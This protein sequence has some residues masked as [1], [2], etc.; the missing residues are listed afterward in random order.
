MKLETLPATEP[1]LTVKERA[2]RVL[3]WFLVNFS[4]A[5]C[6]AAEQLVADALVA[7]AREAS[8]AERAACI[9]VLQAEADYWAKRA[10]DVAAERR[11]SHRAPGFREKSNASRKAAGIVAGDGRERDRK[12]AR[13]AGA[14]VRE[15]EAPRG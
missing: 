8:G 1:G 15:A 2:N 11:Q 3:A 13:A 4:K 6:A 9:A 12:A 10:D 5:S 14:N 7:A